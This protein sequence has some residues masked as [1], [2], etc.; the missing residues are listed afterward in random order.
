MFSN[1]RNRS[2]DRLKRYLLILSERI[3]D[4]SVE[5]GMP[6]RTAAP[7]GPE[8]RPSAASSADSINSFSCPGAF[9]PKGSVARREPASE[10]SQLGSTENGSD[11][12]TM[13]ERSITFWSSRMFP[14]QG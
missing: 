13:T 14:G 9:R 11:S 4:S 5:A 10:I 7:D 3:L 6:S 1:S 2:H 8:M 12:Q